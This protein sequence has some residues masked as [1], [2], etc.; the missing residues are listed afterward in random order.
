MES[1][2][3]LSQLSF[4]FS[5]N[6][7]ERLRLNLAL[8]GSVVMCLAIADITKHYRCSEEDEKRVSDLLS[9]LCHNHFK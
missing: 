7:I 4:Y 5:P 9:K 1:E 3:I 2:T 8:K 6:D